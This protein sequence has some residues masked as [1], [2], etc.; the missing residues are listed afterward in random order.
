M[1]ATSYDQ[2][3]MDLRTAGLHTCRDMMSSL[4]SA[5]PV[6]SLALLAD[7][8][9]SPHVGEAAAFSASAWLHTSLQGG[10]CRS[11]RRLA[12]AAASTLSCR[13]PGGKL[14]SL[15]LSYRIDVPREGQR[16][17]LLPGGQGA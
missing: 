9:A 8:T 5:A 13:A 11:R 6:C 2:L 3:S 15:T 1:A 7:R 17:A 4:L 10:N 12:T 14:S 16:A